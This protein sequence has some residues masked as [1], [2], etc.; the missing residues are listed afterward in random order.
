M[1]R[2]LLVSPHILLFN[3]HNNPERKNSHCPHFVDAVT[4]A[5]TGSIATELCTATSVRLH[6]PPLRAHGTLYR[7]FA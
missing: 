1:A 3:P 5:D 4:E 2:Y 7:L 6:A